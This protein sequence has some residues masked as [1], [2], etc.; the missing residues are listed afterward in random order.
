MKSLFSALGRVFARVPVL[1]VLAVCSLFFC[2]ALLA[3][4]PASADAAAI[5]ADIPSADKALLAK[6]AVHAAAVAGFIRLIVWGLKSPLLSFIWLKVPVAA[7]PAVLL[8]LGALAAAFDAIALGTPVHEAVFVAF[9]GVIGAGG[10]HE[11]QD[12]V[13]G[14][15]AKK[16]ASG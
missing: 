13:T 3:E 6:L 10:S 9:G 14:A 16:K 12:S 8:A 1:F 7:R 2:T 4:S 15:K 11:S 5:L